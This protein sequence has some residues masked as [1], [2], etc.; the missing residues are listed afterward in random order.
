MLDSTEGH[1]DA[2][3]FGNFCT[4]VSLLFRLGTPDMA[5]YRTRVLFL[6]L[7]WAASLL[8]LQVVHLFVPITAYVSIPL[9][10]IGI[11]ACLP[12]VRS[13]LRRRDVPLSERIGLKFWSRIGVVLFVLALWV[14]ARSMLPPTHYDTG[15]YYFN[16]IRWITTFPQV[17]GLGNLHGRLAF[18]QSFFTYA[19]ALDFQPFWGHGRSVANSLLLLMT[20]A[21]F[22]EIL[23]PV[24]QKPALLRESHPFRYGAA[25]IALPY[26]V[27]LTITSNGIASPT[28]DLTSTLLQTVLF[29]LLAS[30]LGEWFDG[31]KNQWQKVSVGVVLAATLITIKL[32]NIIFAAFITAFCLGYAW[33][34]G[35]S[36]RR[37]ISR[38]ILLGF[39]PLLVWSYT[40][41][42]SEVRYCV[43][44]SQRRARQAMPLHTQFLM[45]R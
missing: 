33:Q 31:E 23:R 38:L 36:R 27:Y 20:L 45:R 32:S 21:A 26:L 25:L 9:F 11:A 3:D 40:N 29:V 1:L 19:A 37:E 17:P 22:L 2:H 15:L 5:S 13:L 18:N 6:W 44:T 30:G 41:G 16:S 35:N 8:V 42:V 24:L 4:S 28:P 12:T 14:A 39:L 34:T 43:Q 7:G 10:A